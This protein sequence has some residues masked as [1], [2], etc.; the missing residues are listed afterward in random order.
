MKSYQELSLQLY[1]QIL[2]NQKEDVLQ[3]IFGALNSD[4]QKLELKKALLYIYQRCNYFTQSNHGRR[5]CSSIGNIF[6]Y[7]V[8]EEF[9]ELRDILI[10]QALIPMS[11]FNKIDSHGNTVL[12][13]AIENKNYEEMELLLK[14]GSNP[15][16]LVKNNSQ[17]ILSIAVAKDDLKA[18]A[19]L[20]KYK[21]DVPRFG[22]GI[23][24]KLFDSLVTTTSINS[25]IAPD[26]NAYE[27][28]KLLIEKGVTLIGSGYDVFR[29]KMK[30]IKTLSLEEHEYIFEERKAC[31]N[32]F[33]K[34]NYYR[35]DS[36][37][38]NQLFDIV[39]V[40]TE[41]AKILDLLENEYNKR[42]LLNYTIPL[43]LW[44]TKN[45]QKSNIYN[46]PIEITKKIS[47]FTRN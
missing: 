4:E 9:H 1:H 22:E 23:I 42:S 38:A 3:T 16:Q 25:L 44:A 2:N 36:T 18:V 31:E 41:T 12:V 17:S 24:V 19:L 46:I 5:Y 37:N 15:N 13:Y 29:K 35:M 21:V 28:V 6:H 27:I 20:I 10:D 32:V 40:H 33:Y 34:M 11:F 26:P 14:N 39:Y 45:D 30:N 7:A 47:R 43:F 8:I